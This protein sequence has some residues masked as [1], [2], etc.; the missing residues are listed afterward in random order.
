MSEPVIQLLIKCG[1]ERIEHP[2]GTLLSHLKR[3]SALLDAWSA[4]PA[5]QAA[6]L[7]HAFYGTDGFA[8]ALVDVSDDVAGREQVRELSLIHISE[9][10]R[11]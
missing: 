6:G 5:L 11:H 2:G 10:T 3:V 9:P 8:T 7:G 4:R 1:A